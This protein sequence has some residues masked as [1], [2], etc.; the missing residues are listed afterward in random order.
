MSESF[1]AHVSMTT[2]NGANP[3]FTRPPERCSATRTAEGVITVKTTEAIA[4]GSA[5]IAAAIG[6]VAGAVINVI[7]GA[8]DFTWLVSTFT[9]AAGALV[10]DDVPGAVILLTLKRVDPA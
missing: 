8:D 3:T 2:Q 1:Q 6:L 4:T 7:K 10:A 5:D 9:V